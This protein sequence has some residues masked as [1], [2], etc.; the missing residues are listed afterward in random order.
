MTLSLVKC[1]A[2]PSRF[3]TGRMLPE[4]AKEGRGVDRRNQL[5]AD[6]RLAEFAPSL[7]PFRRSNQKSLRWLKI[8]PV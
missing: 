5:A 3:A 7:R 1:R 2:G 8:F 6:G 4:G